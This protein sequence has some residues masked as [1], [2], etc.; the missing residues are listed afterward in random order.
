MHYK[1]NYLAFIKSISCEFSGDFYVFVLFICFEINL[2]QSLLI[3]AISK[4]ETFLI[5][6]IQPISV[7]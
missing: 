3:R 2:N 1:E 5:N 6:H 7:Q 4:D